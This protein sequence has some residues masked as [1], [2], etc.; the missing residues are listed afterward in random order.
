MRT[1]PRFL[2]DEKGQRIAVVLDIADYEKM[3]EE[4]EEREDVRA[5]DELKTSGEDVIPL[6]QAIEEIERRKK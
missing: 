5:C 4:L 2:I 1:P 6:E 3:L